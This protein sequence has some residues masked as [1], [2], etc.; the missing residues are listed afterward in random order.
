M[1]EKIFLNVLFTE[2]TAINASLLVVFWFVQREAKKVKQQTAESNKTFHQISN[3]LFRRNIWSF[4][5]LLF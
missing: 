2:K 5:F 1:E 4:R 3:E